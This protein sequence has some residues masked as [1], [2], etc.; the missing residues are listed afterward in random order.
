[1]PG[2]YRKKN[3]PQC[4]VEHR[5]RGPFCSQGCHNSHRDVSDKQREHGRKMGQENA[6][7]P[8][9]IAKAKMLNAGITISS[10]EFAVDIP[11]IPDL[12]DGYDIADKW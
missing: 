5:K 12:P 9:L 7:R 10:E 1:M 3:C 2:V 11:E 6:G 8:D 4:G